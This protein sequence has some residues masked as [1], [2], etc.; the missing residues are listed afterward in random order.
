[1]FK[2]I[3]TSACSQINLPVPEN[4]IQISYCQLS[5]GSTNSGL[6]GVSE[7][8]LTHAKI[9]NKKKRIHKGPYVNQ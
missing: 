9:K 2:S 1:M 8:S 3:K 6:A 7:V 5:L 4:C